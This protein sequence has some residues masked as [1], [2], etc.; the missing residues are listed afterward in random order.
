MV[1]FSFERSTQGVV[2]FFEGPTG[3]PCNTAVHIH[4][5]QFEF[6]ERH[7]Y[8]DLGLETRKVRT[9]AFRRFEQ[10]SESNGSQ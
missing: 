10:T 7:L 2:Y 8:P 5:D 9:R 3:C 4:A 6:D 1:E